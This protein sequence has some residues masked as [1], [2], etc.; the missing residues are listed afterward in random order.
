MAHRDQREYGKKRRA[1]RTPE[2]R[3]KELR[4]QKERNARRTPE[5][6]EAKRQHSREYRA[7][8]NPRPTPEQRK[9]INQ[10]EK[11]RQANR[12][13]EQR[14]KLLRHRRVW[15]ENRSP[16]Q[17][18][19]VR[20]RC[21]KYRDSIQGPYV[22]GLLTHGTLLKASDIPKELIEA[23]RLQIKLQRQAGRMI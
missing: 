10:Q 13:P 11:E 8:Y 2:Q 3:E 1:N 20:Q 7:K 17:V 5:Q 14:E 19:V 21:R 6:K 22:A 9:V 18:E 4:Q 16:E 15:Y 23:K 12:T